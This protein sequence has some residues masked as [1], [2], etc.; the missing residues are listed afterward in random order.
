MNIIEHIS[1]IFYLKILKTISASAKVLIFFNRP[2]KKY[3]SLE[4][5]LLSIHVDR[6]V[7]SKFS[8]KLTVHLHS[9][10][11]CYVRFDWIRCAA[12]IAS[13]VFQSGLQDL[14]ASVGYPVHKKLC[15][16]KGFEVTFFKVS[17]LHKSSI[18]CRH[19]LL[20]WNIYAALR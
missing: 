4:T 18:C 8:E 7:V 10:S 9:D 2:L 15:R 13:L 6:K 1:M 19:S 14:Q 12:F 5:I 17:V 16:E 3:P 20:K 11:L